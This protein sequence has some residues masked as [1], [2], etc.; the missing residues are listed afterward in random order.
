M[1]DKKRRRGEFFCKEH[2]RL[3]GIIMS[4]L[5]SFMAQVASEVGFYREWQLLEAKV[6]Y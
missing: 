2:A 1:N 3:L 6:A 5:S 4:F